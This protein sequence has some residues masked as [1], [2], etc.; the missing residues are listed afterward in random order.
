MAYG[1]MINLY[2]LTWRR[3][4]NNLQIQLD[5]FQLSLNLCQIRINFV[6]FQIDLVYLPTDPA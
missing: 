6:Q 4:L 1:N 2:A 5:L 3:S